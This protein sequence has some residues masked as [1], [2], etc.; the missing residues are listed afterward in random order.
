MLTV[1]VDEFIRSSGLNRAWRALSLADRTKFLGEIGAGNVGARVPDI[2]EFFLAEHRIVMTDITE[3][4]LSP[5]HRFK[6]DFYKA[7]MQEMCGPKGPAVWT[8]D[9]NPARP[10][11]GT[12]PR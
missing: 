3:D 2:A 4:V 7:A 10:L 9:I 6:S 1:P 5:L 11:V 8:Q 12:T